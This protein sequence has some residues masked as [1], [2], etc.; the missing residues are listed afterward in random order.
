MYSTIIIR[1]LHTSHSQNTEY[2]YQIPEYVCTH[3]YANY[4]ADDLFSFSSSASPR[5]MLTIPTHA[6]EIIWFK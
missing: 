3:M 6:K 4:S 1:V 2:R 5:N